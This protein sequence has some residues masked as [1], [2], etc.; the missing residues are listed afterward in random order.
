M[1]R[2]VNF[3]LAGLLYTSV[4]SAQ[5]E[6]DTI[7]WSIDLDDVVVTA[8]FAP[9]SSKNAIHQVQVIEAEEIQ[10]QGM[11]NLGEVLSQQLNFQV[12][13][14]PILGNGVRIQGIGG[15]NVQILID[16][17]PVIGRVDGNI[18]LSQIRLTDLERIEMIDGA[19]SAQYGNNA[20]GG[21][22]N[23]ITKKSQLER[24]KVALNNQYENIGIQNHDVLL[25]ANLG[26]FYLSA[27][28][29]YYESDFGPVDSLRIFEDVLLADSSTVTQRRT[30]WNPKTQFNYNSKVVYR[31][32]DSLTIRYQ[33]QYFDESVFIYGPVKRPTFR[34]YAFDQEYETRRSDHSVQV[35]GWLSPKWYLSS[36]TAFNR[37]DRLRHYRE[38]DLETDTTTAIA[39]EQ[40]TTQ[41]DAWLHRTSISSAL[42]G[43]FNYQFGLE[44]LNEIGGGRRIVD[45]SSTDPNQSRINNIAAWVS[46]RY[47]F[48][49]HLQLQGN[50]RYGH[51]SKFDHPLLPAVNLS[52]TPRKEWQ[53]KASY[54]LGFRAPTLKELHFRF[55][56]INHFIIGNPDLKAE[57]SQNA[58]LNINY[59]PELSTSYKVDFGLKVFYNQIRDRITLAEFAPLQ[60]NYQN[61]ERFETH[62]FNFTAKLRHKR[63]Q[64]RTGLS[65][66][67]LLNDWTNDESLEDVQQFIPLT[68]IQTQ[69]SY[70]IPEV[71]IDVR[72]THRYIARQQRFY[73]EDEKLIQGFVGNNNQ[74]NITANRSFWKDRITLSLGVKNLLNQSTQDLIGGASSGGAHSSTGNSILTG[75]ERS[76]FARVQ[77][78][79]QS[80]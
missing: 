23:L 33:Q 76:W 53:I 71:E 60:F 50:L 28:G 63:L 69:L 40:D 17:V 41:F 32:H 20:A 18:D 39:L 35:E 55:I 19:L 3:I 11:V 38:R 37:Y 47:K 2:A 31:P 8:Q 79:F 15:E 72:A 61:L 48:N 73:I 4:L 14:D 5:V 51:N 52:W 7:P 45:S 21:V 74:V 42:K 10:R 58:R 59:S 77:W 9:T 67:R 56:D 25:S 34:P 70:L 44:Y 66:T 75:F 22:I 43:K 65:Y 13:K 30:P 6:A 62:G 78:Q 64:L 24:V 27:G 36:Q 80:N 16:G 26:R 49:S 57:Y 12:S 46:L 54:A 1:N 68:E 29:G